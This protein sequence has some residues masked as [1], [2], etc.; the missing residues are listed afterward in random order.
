MFLFKQRLTEDKKNIATVQA[1]NYLCEFLETS[2]KAIFTDKC[3]LFM[4]TNA[5]FHSQYVSEITE[6]SYFIVTNER[7]VAILKDLTRPELH[8]IILISEKS[9]GDD[10]S[11]FYIPNNGDLVT[12]GYAIK[13]IIHDEPV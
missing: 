8:K 4:R 9:T 5:I 2:K 12:I 3:D 1:Y 6:P 13:E 7:D 11:I 10:K